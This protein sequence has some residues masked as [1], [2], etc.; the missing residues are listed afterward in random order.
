MTLTTPQ[1]VIVVGTGISGSGTAWLLAQAGHQVTLVEKD[2]RIGGHT[3]T[4]EV[5][6]SGKTHAVDMGFIVF[7]RPNYPHLSGLFDYL[8]V[9]T[10]NT[11]MS[12]AVSR[13]SGKHQ[14]GGADF[15][16]FM[17]HSPSRW[18]WSHWQLMFDILRFNKVALSWL[19]QTAFE[20]QETL[21]NWL[22]RH[23]FHQRLA[24]A[25]LLPMSAAIWSCPPAQMLEYPAYSLLSFFKN[26]GLL[27]LED[28]PQW[29][30]VIGGSR[31]YLQ[32]LHQHPNI[33]IVSGVSIEHIQRTDTQV[34]VFFT[35]G[36]S[37]I[38]DQL[39]LATHADQALT[40]LGQDASDDEIE[41]LS[42]FQYQANHAY[43]HSDL[44]Y[45]PGERKVWSSWNFIESDAQKPV[46]VS[47]WMNCLQHIESD[48]PLIVT[49][50][51]NNLPNVDLTW[52]YHVFDH[53]VFTPETRQAQLQL[54]RLQG[55]QRTWFAGSY[56]G[57]GFHEDGFA[58]AVAIAQA[59]GITPPWTNQP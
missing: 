39:V 46:Q 51:P 9:D 8:G 12:F 58:S 26:H 42:P 49:L 23:R 28:R 40:L 25:Y 14:Y 7:N 24:D 2:Q 41:L 32:K 43:L 33:H 13:D 15:A 52:Q 31:N 10:H 50:N 48:R 45:M 29:E 37:L 3:C 44:T 17:A 55:K 56:F 27:Q 20:E 59:W 21:G 35:E 4:Q 36:K 18:R 6:M 34:E 19:K 57:H 22:A 5:K 30:T 53:P 11:E 38:A 1:S 47:Y 54:H 16:T